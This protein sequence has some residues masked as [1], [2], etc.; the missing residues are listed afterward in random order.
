M[1]IQ[2]LDHVAITVA[3]VERTLEFYGRVPTVVDSTVLDRLIELA[4]H[5]KHDPDGCIA[6]LDALPHFEA[7]ESSRKSREIRDRIEPLITSASPEVRDGALVCAVLLGDRKAKRQ[8]LDPYDVR[9]QDEPTY[10]KFY[11]LRGTVLLQIDEP[12][13]A[14]KDLRMAL[15]LIE[16]DSAPR[17]HE[18]WIKLARA[19]VLTRKFTRARQTLIDMQM[20][21]DE[22]QMI[23]KDPDFAEFVATP[24]YA[25]I[26]E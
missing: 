2:G 10:Y 21:F 17:Y 16:F 20:S 4:L 24:R 26:F 13:D 9:I 1:P 7:V 3:D 18:L 8:L 5:L 14:A 23:L 19:Y 12:A 6:V 11:D 22:R 15:E 25:K